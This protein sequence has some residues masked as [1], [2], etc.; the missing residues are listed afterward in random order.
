MQALYWVPLFRLQARGKRVHAHRRFKRHRL[1]RA[2]QY[3][4][5]PTPR[6]CQTKHFRFSGLPPEGIKA[7]LIC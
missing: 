5:L 2:P 4:D 7:A 6:F 3:R 1:Q